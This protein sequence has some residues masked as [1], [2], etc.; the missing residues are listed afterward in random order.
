MSYTCSDIFESLFMRSLIVS[1]C[2]M[3]N[4]II[5][6]APTPAAAQSM[7][8][9]RVP[10]G[11]TNPVSS[12][13]YSTEDTAFAWSGPS[14]RSVDGGLTWQPFNL[15]VSNSFHFIDGRNGYTA[16]YTTHL[17]YHTS[18]GGQHWTSANDSD[19]LV[20]LVC[21]VTTDT[22]FLSGSSFIS[23]TTDAGKSWSVQELDAA[24]LNAIAFADSRHGV[25]VGDVQ[26]GPPPLHHELTAGC[27]TTNDGGLT[28]VQQYTGA[29]N[30]LLA[31][32]WVNGDTLVSSGAPSYF[33]RSTSGGKTWDSI[34]FPG[35]YWSIDCKASRIIAVGNSGAIASSIDAGLTWRSQESGVK[36]LLFSVSMHDSVN[37]I[38]AGDAGVILKTSNGGTSWIQLTPL[39]IESLNITA[40]QLP[41]TPM[42]ELRY[43]L[44]QLQDVTIEVYDLLG[45]RISTL[46][47]R[48]LE[49]AGEHQITLDASRYPAGVYLFRIT[50]ERY[51]GVG[52]IVLVK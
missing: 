9:A 4:L 46:C 16:G 29:K 38:A 20:T 32:C 41:E 43:S 44:P 50:T 22:C 19:Q 35:L 7:G 34:P 42:I 28:W 49:P 25:V 10:S 14:L 18:D 11:T 47:E 21:P 24:G 27:F 31:V 15:P 1:I 6:Q 45:K 13:S 17:A 33:T 36:S 12:I 23:R 5:A 2:C 8:W 51:N 52:K 37:A 30:S 48:K 40:Q 39:S 26:P 3:L